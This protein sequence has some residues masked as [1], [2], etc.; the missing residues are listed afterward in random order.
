MYNLPYTNKQINIPYLL[1]IGNGK[2]YKIGKYLIDK[3]LS[4]VALFLGEGTEELVGAEL[5]RGFGDNGINVVHSQVVNDISIESITQTAFQL[6]PE[7]DAIIGIG[8]GKALDFAK[9]SAHLLRL[10]FVSVPT[11]TSNDGFC[12]PTSSLTVGGRRKTV[13]SSIPFGVVIDLDV[14]RSCPPVFFYSGLGD[15]VSKITALADWKEAANRKLERYS[16]FAS[17]LSYN[18]LDLLFIKHSY[19][20]N[21]PEF[22]RSLT[23]SLLMSGIAMEVAGTSRPASGSEHLISHALDEVSVRPQMHGLQVGTAAYLCA[24]LQNNPSTDSLREILHKTGFF[25]FVKQNPFKKSEFEAALKLAP[26]IK[27]GFYTI[28][29][30]QDSYDKALSLI[31]TDPILQELI[32]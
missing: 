2:T 12:S 14:I 27:R 7:T 28:L 6:P 17:M 24:M 31:N 20:I 10:P 32:K 29:S 19:N 22:Q 26:S 8:G 18:S 3:N 4:G 16:D 30:E 13:K 11:S 1:K 23:T 9:Y 15:M 21:A 5:R 25:D